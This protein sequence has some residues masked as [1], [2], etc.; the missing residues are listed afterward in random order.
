MELD[1]KSKINSKTKPL[2]SLGKLE[3][4]AL[5]IGK[6][7][8][9]LSPFLSNPTI[10]IFAAD[11][12]ITEE[13][14]S[15]FP[16]EVTRQMLM[17]FLHGGAAINV[18]CRLNKISLEVVDAGVAYEFDKFPGLIHAKIEHGT[19]NILKEPAM[20]IETCLKAIG[21]GKELVAVEAAKGCNIIGFGEMGIGNTS[22]ASLLMHKFT[23]FTIEE[24]TGRGTGHDDDSLKHK[25]S[26]LQK[27]AA[28]YSVKD[29]VEILATYG[30]LEIA[31]MCGAMMGARENGMVILVDGFIATAAMLSASE[32]DKSVIDNA[33]FCHTSDEKG[34]EL[35]LNYLNVESILNLR[36]RLGEGTGVAVAYPLIKA[37]VAF[38]NEM[39][40]FEDAGI[41]NI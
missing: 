39:A 40:S 37:A 15:P 29:P 5:Q 32:I 41:S 19:R 13:G 8:K 20:S 10:L 30:G 28:L 14:V 31:M 22:S 26:V 17:N 25:I 3:D 24:C 12:G 27:A 7:Q 2:G 36:M 23:H 34:H 1:L 4:I 33:I 16:K 21:K 35:L 9:T 6:I 18:F 38:L 11:H